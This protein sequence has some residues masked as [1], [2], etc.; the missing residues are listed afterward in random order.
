VN[1][2]TR[3]R[4]EEVAAAARQRLLS[5]IDRL[6]QRKSRFTHLPK[7]LKTDAKAWTRRNSTSLAVLG[8]SAVIAIAG[9]TSLYIAGAERK[10]RQAMQRR[11]R[12][13]KRIWQ[14]PELLTRRRPS[15]IASLTRLLVLG[16]TD[17]AVLGLLALEAER[18]SRAAAH[19]ESPSSAS[20]AP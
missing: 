13:A 19:A 17:A 2:E 12:V 7:S 18:A 15:L 6:E 11:W 1:P 9:A 8:G 3:A 5:T 10:K 20:Q 4:L 16:L 14:E